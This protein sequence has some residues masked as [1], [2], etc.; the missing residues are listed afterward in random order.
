[1]FPSSGNLPNLSAIWASEEC[2]ESFCAGEN[3]LT[4]MFD[5]ML[6][7]VK[8]LGQG[9]QIELFKR[10]IK[11]P[12][13]EFII[14]I[15]RMAQFIEK[16]SQ[17]E[18]L[19][20]SYVDGAND[21]DRG[22]SYEKH[23]PT[24]RKLGRTSKDI[25]WSEHVPNTSSFQSE[26]CPDNCSRNSF[27]LI[28]EEN[29][30]ETSLLEVEVPSEIF[31]ISNT[32]EELTIQK[33]HRKHM[34]ME[35]CFAYRKRP[36]VL[37]DCIKV[38]VDAVI[39]DCWFYEQ[40]HLELN[41]LHSAL[42]M[43]L[44]A[45]ETR[46]QNASSCQR[47]TGICAAE[48]IE[49]PCR[50]N[51]N[52]HIKQAFHNDYENSVEKTCLKETDCVPKKK[53]VKV[54]S[55]TGESKEN[56]LENGTSNRGIY[57]RRS[58]RL[59]EL[60]NVLLFLQALLSSVCGAPQP[61][62]P[63]ASNKEMVQSKQIL[64]TRNCNQENLY[65]LNQ[66]DFSQLM[67]LTDMCRFKELCSLEE[68]PVCLITQGKDVFV[69]QRKNL[70]CTKDSACTEPCGDRY[71]RNDYGVVNFKSTEHHQSYSRGCVTNITVRHDHEG[72]LFLVIVLT[73]IAC[74]CLKIDCKCA[75]SFCKRGEQF[76]Q[77]F[78]RYIQ[79]EGAIVK[80][81][82]ISQELD[83]SNG[84]DGDE[85]EFNYDAEAFA[86]DDGA[87]TDVDGY[88]SRDNFEDFGCKVILLTKHS[89]DASNNKAEPHLENTENK[90]KESLRKKHQDVNTIVSSAD[91]DEFEK[92]RNAH[93]K[94]S[95]PVSDVESKK[96][97][98]KVPMEIKQKVAETSSFYH[99]IQAMAKFINTLRPLVVLGMLTLVDSKSLASRSRG[100]TD[101]NIYSYDLLITSPCSLTTFNR[102]QPCQ[103]S[104]Y[105]LADTIQHCGFQEMCKEGYKARCV[106]TLQGGMAHICSP[107]NLS[108]QEGIRRKAWIDKDNQSVVRVQEEK[109]PKGTFQPAKSNCFD[110]CT[111]KHLDTTNIPEKYVLYR[112]GNASSA[113]YVYCN[114]KKRYFNLKNKTLLNYDQES[115]YDHY[116]C[117][118][119]NDIPPH[120]INCSGQKSP[121]P[122][123]TCASECLPGECRDD[124]D[125]FICKL[126]CSHSAVDSD[127]DD[128]VV[129]LNE[130]ECHK[131]YDLCKNG[132]CHNT[133]DG[134]MCECS[135]GFTLDRKT[136]ECL[137]TQ[138]NQNVIEVYKIQEP[139]IT[140]DKPT[141]TNNLLIV[142]SSIS[143]VLLLLLI[144]LVL[145]VLCLRYRRKT[146]SDAPSTSSDGSEECTPS[147]SSMSTVRRLLIYFPHYV[148]SE[149]TET[150][151]MNGKV[152]PINKVKEM[153]IKTSSHVV[154]E[155]EVQSVHIYQNKNGTE[156]VNQHSRKQNCMV[157]VNRCDERFD[158]ATEDR[159]TTN[160]TDVTRLQEVKDCEPAFH[161]DVTIPLL[162]MEP[163]LGCEE[164][165]SSKHRQNDD[166]KDLH[167]FK[168]DID[169]TDTQAEVIS[170]KDS[171]MSCGALI[172]KNKV[173]GTVFRVG[174]FFVMTAFHV[175]RDI[176][177]DPTGKRRY[178]YSRLENS[179]DVT[180]N[181][182][183]SILHPS[184]RRFRLKHRFHDEQLDVAILEIMDITDLE[185]IPK[186]LLLWKYD[187]V[188]LEVKKIS[189]IGFGHAGNPYEKYSETCEIIQDF[190]KRYR[191]ALAS[192]SNNRQEYIDDLQRSRKDPSFVDFGYA[193]LDSQDFIK[194]DCFMTNGL[195]GGP[196][197]K[198]D[199][200]S[201]KVIGIVLGGKPDFYYQLSTKKQHSFEKRYLFEVG[202]KMQMIYEKIVSKDR[203]LAEQIF[204][205]E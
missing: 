4:R 127:D 177:K 147:T 34:Q 182:N 38:N 110:A 35:M 122:N 148:A 151:P 45:Q 6:Q 55:E 108:C 66:T 132:V 25:S 117:L 165:E 8:E 50:L 131:D 192:L 37:Y 130:D 159:Q 54:G 24:K 185:D 65:D 194:F 123:G 155:K 169:D 95:R 58:W 164:E 161:D 47:H 31:Q 193:N 57:K 72:V 84:N 77:Y 189:M 201:T 125:D 204:Y 62:E 18:S 126:N 111:E 92:G 146:A 149:V 198:I 32:E 160:K 139:D 170:K 39:M 94:F 115:A 19:M 103:L 205:G 199:G 82:I 197:L 10:Y 76:R 40:N 174:A 173:A 188:H 17:V 156:S 191:E 175:I 163:D 144:V 133:P 166:A 12:L 16:Q 168:K 119:I 69:C 49:E 22:K 116:F 2:S 171:M 33:S 78:A 29:I 181:F 75:M 36:S 145:T 154:F 136:Q 23:I 186:G 143:G 135:E 86:L 190:Q 140:Q 178:V 142:L 184:R 102:S 48:S 53:T 179:N 129:Q 9:C 27:H 26:I 7:F 28:K 128:K 105:Q 59:L 99:S 124:H 64:L 101:Q 196:I 41:I 15:H 106:N 13:Q 51:E 30:K 100:A 63:N 158:L 121:L 44:Y 98:E 52:A 56:I 83:A 42:K 61:T 112:K 71:V 109:C 3:F 107:A 195:S 134:Y 152:L 87:I 120:L 74:Y 14:R 1:M 203:A 90:R 79:T 88:D 153:E 43:W 70:K 118:H 150:K 157:D 85:V 73:V 172:Y 113:T 80:I 183:G 91:N 167:E 176:I 97:N 114:Y 200:N 20:K 81:G 202:M 180:V 46:Y 93:A 5:Y 162:P 141:Y 67:L 138:L 21:P 187:I 137:E 11:T 104:G 89:F 60:I 68:E 96:Q